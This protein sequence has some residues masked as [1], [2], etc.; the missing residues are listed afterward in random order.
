[1]NA[2]EVLT[3][4]VL[5]FVSIFG[6]LNP[7]RAGEIMALNTVDWQSEQRSRAAAQAVVTSGVI[8]FVAAWIGNHIIFRSYIH[9]GGFRVASGL[10]IVVWVLR[11]L[12][13]DEPLQRWIER[14]GVSRV[15]NDF[16]RH[17]IGTTL[18]SGPPAMA[19][20]VLYS[21]ETGELWRRL[22]TLVA[23]AVVLAISYGTLRWSHKL[24]ALFGEVGA[25]YTS[26]AIRLTVLSWAVD[27][28][29]VGVRDL[30]P[31]VLHTP[32]AAN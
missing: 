3:Y 24:H 29:A 23:L 20:V 27:F 16:G 19:T 32:P 11:E 7:L 12:I 4:W 2:H 13:A 17:P 31:L 9:T 18:L 5:V 8:L 15:T 22:V 26:H 6:V 1:M 21:G 28:T 25:R 10:L 30:L 14:S